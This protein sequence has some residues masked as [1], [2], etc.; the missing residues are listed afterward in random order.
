MSRREAGVLY[1]SC[2]IPAIAYPLPATWLPDS[3]FEKVHR[4]STSTILNKMGYHRNLPRCLVFAPRSVGGIG[5]CNLQTEMEVQQIMILLRHMR[6]KSPLGQAIEILLRQYQLWAGVSK[7]ILQDTTPY[8]WIPDRWISRI[9]RTMNARNIQIEYQAWV[10]PPLRR[11]D[12]F[13]MEA[14]HELDC[15]P[16]QLEKINACRMSLQVTTLAEITDHTGTMILPHVLST[17]ASPEP[18]GL[19]DLS[20]STLSWPNIHPPSKTCWKLWT[21]TLCTLFAGAAQQTK[22]NHPLGIWLP[23]Y[24]DVRTWHWRLSPLGSLLHQAHSATGI[25][26]LSSLS[27]DA[28]IWLSRL[29]YPQ[30][31]NLVDHQ[32]PPLTN[33]SGSFLYQCQ[34]SSIDRR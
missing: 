12:V 14:I 22:L 34:G 7:P 6:A 13:L 11:N 23:L 27:P 3:F 33:F 28:P 24:Q 10:I 30:T 26:Q 29:Q 25:W 8:S 15:T 5:L 17:P 19:Q 2:F 16:Q 31:K 21:K 18:S 4:L 1:R 20:K 32:S 9:R